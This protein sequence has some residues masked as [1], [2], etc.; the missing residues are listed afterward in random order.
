MSES[1]RNDEYWYN[2]RTGRIERGPQSI[3]SDRIGPFATEAE[4]A[5]A[6]QVVEERAAAW[7]REE[8]EA[9]AEDEG[10]RPR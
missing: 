1:K 5:R 2:T 8:A 6:P 9:E 10:R 4:A 7:A 3:L